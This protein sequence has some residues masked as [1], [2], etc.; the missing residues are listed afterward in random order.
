MLLLYLWQEV[1]AVDELLYLEIAYRDLGWRSDGCFQTRHVNGVGDFS[2]FRTEWP[3]NN[4]KTITLKDALWKHLFYFINEL[5]LFTFYSGVAKNLNKLCTFSLS[6][7]IVH[8]KRKTGRL[9]IY[10]RCTF[11]NFHIIYFLELWHYRFL[12]SGSKS[13]KI[14]IIIFPFFVIGFIQNLI[15]LKN[16][17]LLIYYIF[18]SN[19]IRQ[20]LY[21]Q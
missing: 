11:N 8:I 21:L 6:N 10:F 13:K 4:S 7:E 19:Q 1:R 20:I 3:W 17:N 15:Y 16:Y 9:L 2:N 5:A 14:I 18:K 12:L